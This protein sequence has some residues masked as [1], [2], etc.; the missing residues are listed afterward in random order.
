[1]GSL[2]DQHCIVTLVERKS[3]YLMI[4]KLS[5][6]NMQQAADATI[7]LIRRMPHRFQTITSDNGTEFHSYKEVE[8]ITRVQYYFATPYHSWERGTN[9]N[10]NGLVRQYLPKRSS[11]A[12]LTQSQC[13]LIERKLNDR[14]RKRHNYLT[15]RQ[16]LF[17]T[18]VALSS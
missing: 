2:N 9:E 17:G 3:G 18:H 16:V 6:R 10:T 14:P 11:M 4:R 5:A 8:L 15:P 1:M 7:A 12:T 13:A